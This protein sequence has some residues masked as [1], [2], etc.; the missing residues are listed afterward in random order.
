MKKKLLMLSDDIRLHSGV[1]TM[2]RALVKGTAHKYDWINIG[3]AVNHPEQG[4]IF[5]LSE[6]VNKQMGITDASVKV[7]PVHGYG[8]ENLL[9]QV[10]QQEKPDGIVHFTDPRFWG[11]LYNMEHEL[12]QTTP[13]MYYNIWDDLPY[14]HWNEPFYD[15]CD[16]L[17]A[18]SK[19]TYNINKHV[20]TTRPRKE[21]VDL[22]YVPHGINPEE[23]YPCHTEADVSAIADI[24]Q[25]MFGDNQPEFIAMF[26]SRNIR[27]KGP[28]DLISG[29]ANFVNENKLGDKAAL[30]MHTD[31]VDEHGT[32]L[33]AVAEN[34][35]PG[36]NIVFSSNK[37]SAQTLNWFYNMA[38]VMCNPSSAEGFGLTHAEAMMSGT[39]T[40]ATVTGGLQDQMGFMK[41]V[42][43]KGKYRY[44]GLEDFTADVPSNSAGKQSLNSGPWTF[45]LFP[46]MSLQGSPQTPYI[47]DSRPTISDITRGL[48]HWYNM[49]KADRA[50]LGAEG[51]TYLIEQGFTE[52][53]MCSEFAKSVDTCFENF[54]PRTKFEL[55]DTSVKYEKSIGALV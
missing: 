52:E 25:Q 14:P 54:K 36:C 12:R 9:R 48:N 47:Y 26:N 24:K 7:I 30:L 32:D 11:W 8:D 34:L 37:V 19:Q 49:S 22:T 10:L 15:C 53:A 1:G 16:L 45:P 5:D 38:D 44:I 6:D 43:G 51:R 46:N 20:C 2:A 13:L 18:I 28:S 4:K 3:G 35:A 50:R 40:I 33:H 21:G 42:S 29:F 41:N 55:I 17:M 27:R 31:I 39:P 23:F